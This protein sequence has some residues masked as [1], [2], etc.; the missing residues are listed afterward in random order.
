MS[1]QSE[2]ARVSIDK[3]IFHDESDVRH[4]LDGI[5][6]ETQRIF[7][8]QRQRRRTNEIDGRGGRRG[9]GGKIEVVRYTH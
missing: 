1:S 4:V 5:M 3:G 2:I 8:H 9:K 7:L 6:K